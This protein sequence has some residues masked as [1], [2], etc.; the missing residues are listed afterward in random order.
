MTVCEHAT[1]HDVAITHRTVS[2]INV[3]AGGIMKPMSCAVAATS[4]QRRSALEPGA[5]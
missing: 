3:A 1:E 2:F 4:R 5:V